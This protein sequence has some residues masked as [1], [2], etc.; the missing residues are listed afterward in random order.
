M[1]SESASATTNV[2]FLVREKTKQPHKR[3][4]LSICLYGVVNFLLATI[5]PRL[6]PAVMPRLKCEG[7]TALSTAGSQH[8]AAASRAAAH[9]EPVSAGTLDLGGLIRTLGSHD[10]SLKFL[11]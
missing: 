4:T 1:R 10:E 8:L 5:L 11:S 3:Q 9:Q 2:P 6:S 7:M